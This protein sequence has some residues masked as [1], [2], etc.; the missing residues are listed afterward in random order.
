[1]VFPLY[2]EKCEDK[3]KNCENVAFLG[4][5]ARGSVA[6]VCE[7]SCKKCDPADDPKPEGWDVETAVPG[8][9]TLWT[10]SESVN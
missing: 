2:S 9:K 5:C 7:K 10:I 1:M 4:L 3:V 8:E 6:D